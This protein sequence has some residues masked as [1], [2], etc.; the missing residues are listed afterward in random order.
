MH[1]HSDLR[2]IHIE[3]KGSNNLFGAGWGCALVFLHHCP[4]LLG[5]EQL[6]PF[7]LSLRSD[8]DNLI[9]AMSSPGMSLNVSLV[10][11]INTEG[12]WSDL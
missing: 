5:R 10:S 1:K 4:W 8:A 12:G 6:P 3:W 11:V 2:D 7:L 9:P